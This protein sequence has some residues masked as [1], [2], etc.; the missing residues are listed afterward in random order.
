MP[1]SIYLDNNA[2]TPL[3]PEIAQQLAELYG[4]HI[5]NPASQH[6]LGRTALALLEQAKTEVLELVGAP[7]QGMDTA[8]IVL[9]S[10]GTEANNLAIHGICMGRPGVIIVGATEHPSVPAAA[11]LPGL[12]HHPLRTL[13]VDSQGRCDL[14]QLQDWLK[15]IYAGTDPAA[16]QV[17]LV[18]IMMG[19]NETGILQDLPTICAICN[20]YG[21]PVH[22]DVVQAVGKTPVHMLDMGLSALTLTAHKIH[23]P[24]GI[25]ALVTLPH[26][27]LQPLL[28]GGGQQL[29]IRA[30]TEPV[31]PAVALA[32]ALRL[33]TEA[34]LQGVY[35]QV[36]TLRDRLEQAM[37]ELG[38]TF[39]IGQ[40]TDRLPHTSNIAF[41]QVDR[42][43]LHMALDLAGLACSAGSAC[44]SGSSR[45]SPVLLAMG[46][47]QEVVH[48]ALRFSL[49]RFTDAAEVDA[50]IDILHRVVGKIRSA[51]GVR[52][53]T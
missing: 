24:V 48:G 13:P 50:A 28:V 51:A 52:S 20:Q 38:D 11:N 12:Q 21:V 47:P 14:D 16:D 6:R 1:S 3:A 53:T 29:G 39:V 45:P 40:E 34:R 44:S 46:L 8:N 7:C 23:G 22:S 33:T 42:Q 35:Q 31:I 15:S 5:A 9:T 25:G 41:G 32:A 43:A 37:L 10:G 49:S 30:G 4:S 18:S 27:Q 19:N 2:T 17:A 26:I 36:A